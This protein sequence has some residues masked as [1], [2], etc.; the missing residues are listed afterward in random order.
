MYCRRSPAPMKWDP[1]PTEC[2]ATDAAWTGGKY[3]FYVSA[4][5]GTVGVMVADSPKGPWIDPIGK[6]LMS[7]C[8]LLLLHAVVGS[9]ATLRLSV[10]Q[11]VCQFV[12][13]FECLCVCMCVRARA[14]LCVCAPVYLCVCQCVCQC[15]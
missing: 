6:A 1:N 12:C 4:G 5:P 13:L 8:V 14:R 11:F 7:A 9:H 15:V 2:W 3:Y 10:C